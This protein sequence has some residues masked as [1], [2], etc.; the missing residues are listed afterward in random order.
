M[1]CWY[2]A[3]PMTCS[4]PRQLSPP[5]P[6]RHISHPK[7]RPASPRAG[8]VLIPFA[9]IAPL[10]LN[11]PPVKSHHPLHPSNL[12][13][14]KSTSPA[15]GRSNFDLVLVFCLL[16]LHRPPRQLAPPAPPR[17]ISHP[18]NRP[19]PPMAGQI[20]ISSCFFAP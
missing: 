2:A 4:T 9:S 16:N 11:T 20:L 19:A 7:L 8:R 10:K 17:Q 18:T 12:T 14:Q 1:T 13:S 5:T 15:D 6:P 3:K